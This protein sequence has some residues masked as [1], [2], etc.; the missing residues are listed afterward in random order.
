M[1]IL[2]L[3]AGLIIGLAIGLGIIR[4]QWPGHQF[5]G[6][7][8]YNVVTAGS[9]VTSLVTTTDNTSTTLRVI[10]VPATSTIHIT[11]QIMGKVTTSTLGGVWNCTVDFSSGVTST[12]YTLGNSSCTT[13]NVITGAGVSFTTSSNAVTVNVNGPG[14]TTVNWKGVIEAEYSQ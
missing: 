5:F 3:L 4:F 8:F 13:N 14:A 9:Q 2:S 7:G 10:T 12:I 6:G 11:A 1:K